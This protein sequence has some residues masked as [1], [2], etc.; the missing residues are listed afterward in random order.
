MPTRSWAGSLC[1]LPRARRPYQ[2]PPAKQQH[3][4]APTG[5]ETDA[6]ADIDLVRCTLSGASQGAHGREVGGVGTQ[7][8]IVVTVA[9]SSGKTTRWLWTDC[10][11]RA[12]PCAKRHQLAEGLG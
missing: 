2:G 6:F 11:H 3:S 1:A 7:T 12:R 10:R 5:F 8:L 4:E 9:A